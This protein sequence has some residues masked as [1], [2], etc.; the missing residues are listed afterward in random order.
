MPEFHEASGGVDEDAS[1]S[2]APINT[3]DG[4]EIGGREHEARGK[5]RHRSPARGSPARMAIPLLRSEPLRFRRAAL[6]SLNATITASTVRRRLARSSLMLPSGMD[7][8]WK[9]AGWR[10]RSGVRGGRQRNWLC[11]GSSRTFGCRRGA[12]S[13]QHGAMHIVSSAGLWARRGGTYRGGE[14]R[15]TRGRCAAAPSA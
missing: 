15:G 13:M 6:E 4:I 2:L 12:S 14:T 8:T 10:Q 9:E 7:T 5:R 3:G 11:S 1:E